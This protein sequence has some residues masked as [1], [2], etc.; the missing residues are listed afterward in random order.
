ML[1][2]PF[3]GR[4]IK[5]MYV[6]MY[7]LSFKK[8]TRLYCVIRYSSDTINFNII[9]IIASSSSSCHHHYHHHYHHVIIIIIV[10]VFFLFVF[11][12]QNASYVMVVLAL[13]VNMD[14][15]FTKAFFDFLFFLSSISSIK[16]CPPDTKQRK[17][18]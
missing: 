14:M 10:V 8:I 16:K 13:Y 4:S 12:L 17:I 1:K 15:R 5:Y 18:L 2:S 9:T 3:R 6:C 7:L 11:V